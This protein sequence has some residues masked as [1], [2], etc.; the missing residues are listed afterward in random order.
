MRM[1]RLSTFVVVPALLVVTVLAGVGAACGRTIVPD[2][3]AGPVAANTDA[4]ALFCVDDDQCQQGETCLGGVCSSSQCLAKANCSSTQVCKLGACVDPPAQCGSSDDCP[5][6]LLCDGFSRLCVNPGG[7]GCLSNDECALV[8]GCAGGCTCVNRACQP[9]GTPPT[10]G[11]VI[12]S[13]DSVDLSGFLVEDESSQPVQHAVQ[14]PNGTILNAGQILVIGRDATKSQFE[15]VWGNLP[16]GVLYLN[17][18]G[19]SGAGLSINGGERMVVRSAVGSAV[20]GPTIAGVSGKSYQR[21][22]A[23]S[24]GS[25]AS[26]TESTDTDATPGVVEL[27][28][29]GVGL[30]LS[31]WSDR[32]GN[33]QF[34]F[35]FIELYY[36]P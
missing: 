2:P 8:T 9:I 3:D 21:T 5:G 19:G 11:G 16:S 32:T 14:I 24:A 36:A 12:I 31:E 6:T 30:V 35:E 1:S 23:G 4:G 28:Q 17:G 18:N 27:P 29:T 26:W 7:G 33:S 15:H 10:D 22:S 13:G 20:D 34:H 25:Q